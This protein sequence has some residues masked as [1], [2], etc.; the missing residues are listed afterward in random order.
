[1]AIL[2]LLNFPPVIRSQSLVPARL[3]G[4]NHLVQDFLCAEMLYP[5]DALEAGIEGKVEL[6]FIVEKD[7]SIS[8]LKIAKSVSPGID[9]EAIRLFRMLLW[10]PAISLGQPV[11]SENEFIINFNIKKYNKHC[12]QRGYE[13]SPYPF[14]PVDTSY[15][16]YDFQGTDKKPFPVFDEKGMRLETFIARNMNYPETAYRQNLSG[17]VSLR[18]VVEPSGRVSNI[19]VEQPVGGGCTQ[20]AIRLLQLIRWMPGI[21]NDMAVRTFMTM[22]ISFRLPDDSDMNM[23]QGG[24]MQ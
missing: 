3:Y 8:Q 7:G 1:V 4:E 13:E 22:D 10:E 23:I 5:S 6:D 17:K 15:A 11:A 16:V 21:K 18:F 12:K 9:R 14:Q 19:K 24:Q 20:E 2:L